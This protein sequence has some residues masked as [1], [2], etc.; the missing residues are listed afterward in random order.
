MQI[1][2]FTDLKITTMTMVIT[3]AAS[4]NKDVVFHLLPITRIP[5]TQKRATSKCKLPHSDQPGTIF[6]V[7]HKGNV[8]G[9]IRTNSGPFKN[10]VTIDIS[11]TVKNLS[12]KLSPTSVQLTGASS[13]EDGVE[14]TTHVINHILNIQRLI[15]R[16]RADTDATADAIEWVKDSTR[17]VLC[18]R[19]YQ[20]IK[21]CSNVTLKITRISYDHSITKPAISTPQHLDH[22]LVS[23]FLSLSDDFLY[24]SDFCRKLDLLP[25]VPNA[26]DQVED[27]PPLNIEHVNAAMVN[28]NYSLGFEVDRARLNMFINNNNG[29]I[30]RFNNEFT[31]CVTVELPY[32]P[33]PGATIKRR[34]NKVPHVT[35]LVYYSGSV[36]LSGP[37]GTIMEDA[38]YL[39]MNTIQSLQPWITFQNTTP[40]A[41]VAM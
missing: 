38:Y 31:N 4:V 27:H 34:K 40:I 24:H 37:G 16:I 30:S 17:G 11:T 12:V 32:E 41:E 36:T 3:L 7:R 20:V 35:F 18:E 10:A 14:A 9:I 15:E 19:E 39:F 28:Y 21:K 2:P 23:L 1:V 8:R 22:E 29:F 26:V 33:P 6:S 25:L 5:V 13:R